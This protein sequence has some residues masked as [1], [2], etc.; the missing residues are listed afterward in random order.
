MT[1]KLKTLV[2]A[3]DTDSAL[4]TYVTAHNRLQLQRDPSHLLTLRAPGR[5]VT[6]LN[7]CRQDTLVHKIK[8]IINLRIDKF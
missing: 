1:H 4:S 6:L 2:L 5:P 7:T 3:E 8:Q